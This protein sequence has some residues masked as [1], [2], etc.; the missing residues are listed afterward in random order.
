MKQTKQILST[1][2][3]AFNLVEIMIAL[4]LSTIILV[5]I[6]GVFPII[7]RSLL[8]TDNE[9]KAG[10]LAQSIFASLR[11]DYFD[12]AD[13]YGMKINLNTESDEKL[14]YADNELNISLTP[15]P[16]KTT[17]L[18]RLKFNPSP[19]AYPKPPASPTLVNQ[20]SMIIYW[21]PPAAVL[22]DSTP[23]LNK[24]SFTGLIAKAITKS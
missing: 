11:A 7:Q 13:L 5:S 4:G 17:F 18:I 1:G 21:T 24:A 14:L 22:P 9:T 6:L 23:N 2:Q 3:K 10:L 15:I 8:D 19:P 20:L 16:G 12:D